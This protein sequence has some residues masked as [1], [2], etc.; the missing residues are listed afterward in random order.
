MW[1]YAILSHTSGQ[2]KTYKSWFSFQG[3]RPED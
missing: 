2:R 3:V 1:T